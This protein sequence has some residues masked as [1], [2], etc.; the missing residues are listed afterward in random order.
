MIDAHAHLDDPRL[1]TEQVIADFEKD[2]I[3]AVINASYDEK[4]LQNGVRMA[5]KYPRVFCTIG[6]HPHDAKT[7]CPRIE[8]EMD[9]LA[10][11][12]KVV[13]VGEVGLDYFRMLSEKQVQR[14]VFAHQIELADKYKLP[15]MLHVRDAYADTSDI[16]LAQKKYLNNGVILHC[17]SGSAETAKMWARRGFYFSFG[18][19]VTYAGNRKSEVLAQI[20]ITQVLT[21]TDSPYLSPEPVRGKANVPANIKYFLPVIAEAYGVSAEKMD[22]QIRENFLRFF[23]KARL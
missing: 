12:P 7:F 23:T 21:E 2:G 5:E 14:D 15:L 19:Q 6:I 13:A 3:E 20:P 10:A 18:G 4:T 11:H 1:N 22:A 8:A 9:R 16:L 17:F